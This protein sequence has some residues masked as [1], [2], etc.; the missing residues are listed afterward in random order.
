MNMNESFDWDI[1]RVLAEIAANP[2]PADV[3]DTAPDS[4]IAAQYGPTITDT[5]KAFARIITGQSPRTTR[6]VGYDD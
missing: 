5:D 3:A 6:Y 4:P 1:V 2:T